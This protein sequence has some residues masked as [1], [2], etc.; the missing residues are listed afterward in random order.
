M[1]RFKVGTAGGA[2]LGEQGRH[3]EVSMKS[4]HFEALE[5]APG[6]YAA[7]ASEDGAGI[8]NAGVVDL[9][10][11]TLVVDTFLTP[12]AG[13]DLRRLAEEVTG[14]A[15]E[16][17]VNT[18]F[19]NDHVWG[20]QAFLPEAQIISS[21]RTLALM[22]TWG[23]EELDHFR[24]SSAGRLRELREQFE[25]ETD[26]RKRADITTWIAYYEGLVEALPTLRVVL[27]TVTFE[28]RLRLHG[29]RQTAELIAFE[30]AHTGGDTVVYLPEAGVAYLADLLFTGCHPYL[31][32]GDPLALRAVLEELQEL[33]ARIFVPGHGQ[34]GERADLQ[35]MIDYIDMCQ[36]TAQGLSNEGE[37]QGLAAPSEYEDWR[38]P[39]F[40]GRN[41]RY[42]MGKRGG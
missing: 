3:K 11:R 19:H 1:I 15:P 42:F 2:G 28:Q 39:Q 13:R 36:R 18:H 29:E 37:I 12:Q 40:F 10:G 6:V 35:R 34:P 20:N 23:V 4:K 21:E 32:D 22:Q 38:Y 25:G 8:A 27:P 16:L 7:I 9:G 41:V 5:L 26:A 31:A 30:R 33:D 14:R 17:V 24:A